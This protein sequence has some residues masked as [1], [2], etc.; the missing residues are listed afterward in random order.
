MSIP[1][2]WMPLLDRL[3]PSPKPQ[4]LPLP[5]DMTGIADALITHLP[6]PRM[7]PILVQRRHQQTTYDDLARHYDVTRER[8]HMLEGMAARLL[9]YHAKNQAWAEKLM[10]LSLTPQYYALPEEHH[11]AWPLLVAA[12]GTHS[13]AEHAERR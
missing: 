6:D 7:W 1:L 10:E 4:G 13:A 3:K 12:A 11:E 2:H 8:I 5:V 9:A